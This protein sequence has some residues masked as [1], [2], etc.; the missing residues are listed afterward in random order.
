MSK[1]TAFSLSM[2]LSAAPALAQIAEITAL[3]STTPAPAGR[4]TT[5]TV[6]TV[7]TTTTNADGETVASTVTAPATPGT[8]ATSATPAVTNETNAPAV[9]PNA[10]VVWVDDGSMDTA[11]QIER[12]RQN[13][14]AGMSA[15]PYL[16]GL[17]NRIS[18]TSAGESITLTGEVNHSQE[19]EAIE[20]LTKDAAGNL[21]VINS[22]RVR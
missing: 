8:A 14:R 6:T 9:V 19:R 16:A 11:S 12:T 10:P 20:R 1:I 17:V 5:T 4:T 18:M 2:L 3:P 13:L 21:R 7:T 15:D 22:I